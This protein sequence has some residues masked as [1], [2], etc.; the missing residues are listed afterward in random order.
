MPRVKPI[1]F[2]NRWRLGALG[3]LVALCALT[4]VP[5]KA[6]TGGIS[7]VNFKAVG[8]TMGVQV[9]PDWVLVAN[10][11]ALLPGQTFLN[12]YGSR[13]VAATY[14]APGSGVFPLNDLALMRLAPAT[15]AAPY[16]AISSTL[17]P[18]GSFPA[19]PATIV[20]GINPFSGRGYAFNAIDAFNMFNDP[21]EGG[22]LGPVVANYL[23]SHDSVMYVEGGDSGGALF[24]GHVLD[25][26]S[27]LLGITS[28]RL[29]D[30]NNVPY[31]SAFVEIS[32]YRSWID[33]T[34]QAD[35]ADNQVL[36]WVMVPEPP[37]ALLWAAGLVLLG[38]WRRRAMAR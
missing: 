31:G 22:P 23:I 27:P 26:V 8:P 32:A 7:T 14:R 21:D 36:Q 15:T 11:V 12:G 6:V 2:V 38:C 20:S 10:H 4:A 34:M 19:V 9:T 18:E 1:R 5:A 28:A 3:G 17:F 30:D 16:L 24:L 35:N 37:A 33:A 29:E 13:T 25:S